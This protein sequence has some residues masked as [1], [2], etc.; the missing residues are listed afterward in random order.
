MTSLAISLCLIGLMLLVGAVVEWIR[1][2]PRY[3]APGQGT[4]H[5]AIFGLIVQLVL[6]G[7]A[8]AVLIAKTIR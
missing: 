5:I 2:W 6:L 7:G 4:Q 8:V 3:R 1:H